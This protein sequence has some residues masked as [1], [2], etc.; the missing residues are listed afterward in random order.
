MSYQELIIALTLL[1]IALLLIAWWLASKC[2]VLEE[3]LNKEKASNKFVVP[4]AKVKAQFSEE[5]MKKIRE[6]L[7]AD[8]IGIVKPV[9]VEDESKKCT[10]DH[11]YD[12][13]YIDQDIKHCCERLI[14]HCERCNHEEIIPIKRGLLTDTLI[15][16]GF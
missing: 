2:K 16:G 6:L 9:E 11:F 1:I 7:R 13:V 14:F 4:V 15:R 5:D 10:C 12:S 3:E 8:K